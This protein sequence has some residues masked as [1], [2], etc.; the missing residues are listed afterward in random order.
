MADT[1]P[2]LAIQRQ[3]LQMTPLRFVALPPECTAPGSAQQEQLVTLLGAATPFPPSRAY[4]RAFLKTLLARCEARCA[5][6]RGDGGGVDERLY[7]LVAAA[8]GESDA[9]EHLCYKIYL[10]QCR[11]APLR[12]SLPVSPRAALERAG[13]VLPLGWVPVVLQETPQVI[14]QG[15]TGLCTWPAAMWLAEWIGEH[16]ALFAGRRVLEL[17]AGVGLASLALAAVTEAASLVLSDCNGQVLKSLE[18]NLLLN[19]LTPRA[20][21]SAASGHSS[22]ATGEV[23]LVEL[24]WRDATPADIACIGAEIVIA[25]DV[26]Y[27]ADIIPHLVK[28]IQFALCRPPASRMCLCVIASTQRNEET[29]QTFLSAWP[30]SEYEITEEAFVPGPST[31]VYDTTCPIFL[32]RI[33]LREA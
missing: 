27:D 3:Y 10:F 15:T 9:E 33:T 12:G 22:L 4:R 7:E 32:H 21:G 5:D 29:L 19:G 8:F 2:F 30:A 14:S 6:S 31:L 11:G 25:A 13:V 26:V 20:A 28:V 24:D 1:T 18:S 17:G 16:A 23:E